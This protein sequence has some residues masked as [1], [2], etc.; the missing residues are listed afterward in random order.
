VQTAIDR[1]AIDPRAPREFSE[2][3]GDLGW[4]GERIRTS[5]KQVARTPMTA[6]MPPLLDLKMCLDKEVECKQM[7]A[8]T[9]L[10]VEQRAFHAE[11]AEQWAR[12]AQAAKLQ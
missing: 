6:Q 4:L 11:R 12:L 5:G 8:D 9:S 10:T 7:S 1:W 3:G 2:H